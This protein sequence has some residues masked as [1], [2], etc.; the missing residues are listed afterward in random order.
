[1]DSFVEGEVLEYLKLV[2]AARREEGNDNA[3][4]LAAAEAELEARE[5]E[6]KLHV[7][8]VRGRETMGKALYQETLEEL[9]TIRNLAKAEVD[10]IRAEEVS[11]DLIEMVAD[12]WAEWTI[13][14]RHEF[15]TKMLEGVTLTRGKEEIGLRVKINVRGSKSG[16][17]LKTYGEDRDNWAAEGIKMTPDNRPEW[18][19][20]PAL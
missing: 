13:Q 7:K 4:R 5:Y 2:P 14:S 16:G 20:H 1:L 19:D 11:D 9:V 18:D 17:F 8:D 3:A 15:L 6:L 12:V 10:A